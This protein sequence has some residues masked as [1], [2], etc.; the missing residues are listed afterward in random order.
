MYIINHKIVLYHCVKYSVNNLLL[1]VEYLKSLSFFLSFFLFFF[2]FFFTTEVQ[3][4]LLLLQT[5]FGHILRV[6]AVN[7]MSITFSIE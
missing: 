1:V 7:R 2:F 4:T 5:K 6:W 3:K